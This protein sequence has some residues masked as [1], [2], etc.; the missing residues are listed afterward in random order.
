MED[1]LVHRYRQHETA[2]L[3]ARFDGAGLVDVAEDDAA[4]D[5][6]VRVRIARHHQHP[7]GRLVPARLRG[8]GVSRFRGHATSPP[9]NSATALPRNLMLRPAM[10]PLA[11]RSSC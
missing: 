6:A 7:D 4:E 11:R 2:A 5:G 9:R 1:D 8:L 10:A 3:P